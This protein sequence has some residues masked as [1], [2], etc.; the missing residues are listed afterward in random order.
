MNAHLLQWIGWAV[1]SANAALAEPPFVFPRSTPEAQGISSSA[2]LDLVRAFDE[3]QDVHSFMLVR[4]GHVVAEGWWSPYNAQ[5]RHSMYSLSKSF[6][7]TAVG[8][9]VA[10]GKLSVDDPVLKFFPNAAPAEPSANLKAMRVADLLRMNTGQHAEDMARFSFDSKEPLVELFLSIPVAHKPGTHFWY[11]TPA[12]FMASAIVQTAT[13][14]TVFDFLKP[15]LFDPLG[16]ENPTWEMRQQ[17]TFGGSGLAIRT[18]DI[19]R[20]GQ[21]YLQ[22]GEWQGRRLVPA[23]WIEAATSRQTSNGSAP[24]SD[25]DQGYGY[26]FWRCR[27]GLYR[28]DGAFGQYCIVLQD[29]DAVVAITSGTRD[30]QGIMNLVWDKLLPALQPQKL[31]ADRAGH[32][33]LTDA[34]GRLTIRP[35]DGSGSAGGAALGQPFVFPANDEKLETVALEANGDGMT[36][37]LKSNGVEQRVACGNRAWEKARMTYAAF[38]NQPVAVSGAWTG[39]AVYT[40]KLCF[41]E[42]PFIVTGR[43][44]FG[45]DQLLYD[46]EYNV[47]FGPTKKP[48]LAGVSQ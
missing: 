13:G 44:Q 22:E 38:D 11:N 27:H 26:Q 48:Q 45:G 19:A 29:Q 9:A 8:L 30:M 10:E 47:S 18:E 14:E 5:S 7:S 41:Y 4:H 39:K 2:I 37:V 25:W 43:F 15:R 34:L 46:A 1:V 36:L 24:E 31:K 28:G 32:A 6:T 42:T 23:E 33:R 3:R 12:T 17:Y 20:F 21:L 40:V 35:Q 16:I